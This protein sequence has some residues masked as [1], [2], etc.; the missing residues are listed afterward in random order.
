[1]VLRETVQYLL[2]PI[3]LVSTV[4]VCVQAV[5]AECFASNELPIVNESGIT[6]DYDGSVF[7]LGSTDSET[8]G[9]GFLIEPENG[10]LITAD[11]VVKD[12]V[13]AGGIIYGKTERNPEP[14][15]EFELVRTFIA[16][17]LDVAVLRARTDVD[18]VEGLQ[19]VEIAFR[20]PLAG[21]SGFGF[22][23]PALH[24][25]DYDVDKFTFG[26]IVSAAT[27]ILT[28]KFSN[29]YSGGPAVDEVGA[30]I[31]VLRDNRR[32]KSEIVL[33]HSIV[34][35]FQNMSSTSRSEEIVDAIFDS[36]KSAEDI[37]PLFFSK[38]GSSGTRSID[39][40]LAANLDHDFSYS[41]DS[42]RKA[43]CLE[44]AIRQRDVE[45]AVSRLSW[46]DEHVTKLEREQKRRKADRNLRTAQVA[47]ALQ[48]NAVAFSRY[49][50][51]SGLYSDILSDDQIQLMTNLHSSFCGSGFAVASPGY[52][53]SSDAL[54]SNLSLVPVTDAT[55]MCSRIA[56]DRDTAAL[57]RDYAT[58]NVG[59][60]R[61]AANDQL[62]E[63]KS[64]AT[65]ASGLAINLAESD[66]AKGASAAIIAEIA[67]LS[68]QHRAANLLRAGASQEGNYDVPWLESRWERSQ[69]LVENESLETPDTPFPEDIASAAKVALDTRA[70]DGIGSIIHDDLA[71]T[72]SHE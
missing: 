55:Q 23:Y 6:R 13:S 37:A 2:K 19:A 18:Y 17:G 11:H 59:I 46:M 71:L 30:A 38:S 24:S 28:G 68:D 5:A 57:L 45:F 70:V 39:L 3:I 60:I 58:A 14:V 10:I 25:F 15:V 43:R 36:Q 31:G 32:R 64:A 1:M 51:A 72:I 27:Q 56:R 47:D 7:A 9:S 21:K 42:A 12:A 62:E 8:V 54:F 48:M 65:F 20:K 33:M 41:E 40:I 34:D 29:G 44:E 26:K 16:E 22:G 63:R 53:G 4:Y 67:D 35:Y 50:A 61:V 69:A 66:F 49:E 52:D